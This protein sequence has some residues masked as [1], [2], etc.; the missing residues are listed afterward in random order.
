MFKQ[1]FELARG[2][3]VLT[4]DVQENRKEIEE[5]RHEL[6]R[7]QDKVHQLALLLQQER[8]EREK[9][10]LQLENVL[11]RFERRLPPPTKERG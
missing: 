5:V 9:L 3:L 4:H 6:D 10:T 11:L 8:S 2:F 1:L 7:M